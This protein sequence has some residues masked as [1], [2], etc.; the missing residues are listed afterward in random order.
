MPFPRP[1]AVGDRSTRS[2]IHCS[3][4]IDCNMVLERKPILQNVSGETSTSQ[5]RMHKLAW[6][7]GMC[8]HIVK[9]TC[10][11]LQRTSRSWRIFYCAD[12]YSGI[13]PSPAI[14]RHGMM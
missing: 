2:G 14:P 9:N 1:I 4:T 8:L 3:R 11:P 12:V 6:A 7:L 5:G 10:F 13:D